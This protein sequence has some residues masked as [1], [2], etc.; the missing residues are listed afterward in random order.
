[1]LRIISLFLSDSREKMIH[2]N[3]NIKETKNPFTSYEQRTNFGEA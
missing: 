1:M 3:M 2:K